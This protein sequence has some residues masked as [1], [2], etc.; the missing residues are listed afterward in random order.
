VDGK[1]GNLG[2]KV[3]ISREKAKIH[4]TVE[5]GS[6]RVGWVGWIA[7]RPTIVGQHGFNHV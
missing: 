5:A 6:I 3:N 7:G 4:V 2:D 1:T